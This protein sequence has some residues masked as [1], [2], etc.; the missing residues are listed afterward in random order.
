VQYR[1]TRRTHIPWFYRFWFEDSRG[2][3][4]QD[5]VAAGSLITDERG[6]FTILFTPLPPPQPLYRKKIPDIAEFV[7]NAEGRD[8]RR[9]DHTCSGNL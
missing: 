9:Q 1:I 3:D 7:I 8:G 4:P 2:D 5:D 6:N